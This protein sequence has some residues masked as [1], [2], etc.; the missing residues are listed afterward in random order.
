MDAMPSEH[1]DDGH[2]W[3]VVAP[4]AGASASATLFY[5]LHCAATETV[6]ERRARLARQ[7]ATVD[8]AT[9]RA[10]A[11]IPLSA[12]EGRILALLTRQLDTTVTAA[13]IARELWPDVAF[14]TRVKAALRAH[15]YTLRRKLRDSDLSIITRAGIGYRAS[16]SRPSETGHRPVRQ[17]G[18]AGGIAGRRSA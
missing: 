8:A 6:E 1:T 15:I 2:T 10:G 7:Q 14:S 5:C 12:S 9:D 13:D 17:R 3:Q 18:S 4:A 16:A 11:E